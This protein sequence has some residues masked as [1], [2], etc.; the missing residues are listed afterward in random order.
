MVSGLQQARLT[1]L[2]ASG[3]TSLQEH[4]TRHALETHCQPK[5]SGLRKHA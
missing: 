1:L 2:T 3:A 4:S 5:L